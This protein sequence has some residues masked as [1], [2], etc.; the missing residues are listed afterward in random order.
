L[1]KEIEGPKHKIL[2][3]KKKK[4]KSPLLIQRRDLRFFVLVIW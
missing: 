4:K 1:K 2:N 3:D